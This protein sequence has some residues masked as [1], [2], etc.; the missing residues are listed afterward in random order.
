MNQQKRDLT[1]SHRLGE[2][3]ALSSFKVYETAGRLPS[4]NAPPA[5]EGVR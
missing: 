4:K 1:G 3:S 5:A 2:G